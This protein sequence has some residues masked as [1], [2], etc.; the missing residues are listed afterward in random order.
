MRPTHFEIHIFI[1]IGHSKTGHS[2]F[3]DWINRLLCSLIQ[4][5]A[6]PTLTVTLDFMNV[7]FVAKA[8]VN[9]ALQF[10]SFGKVFHLGNFQSILF[11]D[12]VKIIKNFGYQLKPVSPNLWVSM[13][14]MCDDN[15]LHPILHMFRN[16]IPTTYN[17]CNVKT[18][19]SL[20]KIQLK[21]DVIDK[22]LIETYLKY[23][24][25]Q[26]IIVKY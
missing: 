1:Y 6:Y 19:Q 21:S 2:N 12:L 15:Y 5:A 4:L 7:D 17:I 22:Q 13:L 23:F 3:N 25:S 9:L 18:K 14:Q 11:L 24:I 16:G 20:D 26:N 10:D 8:I